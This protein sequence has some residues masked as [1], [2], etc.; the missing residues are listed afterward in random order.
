MVDTVA[1]RQVAG[2]WMRR[3]MVVCLGAA[4]VTTFVILLLCALLYASDVIT[5]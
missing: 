3:F 5:W 4:G 2:I 1:V